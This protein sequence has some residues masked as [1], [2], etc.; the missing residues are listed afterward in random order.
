[1]RQVPSA[2]RVIARMVKA[3]LRLSTRKGDS[4]L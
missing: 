2:A 1:M 3:N 4:T